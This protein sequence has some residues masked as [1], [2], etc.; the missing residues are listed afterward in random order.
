VRRHAADERGA[1]A[2]Y[3][4]LAGALIAGSLVLAVDVGR[5][6][7]V[8]TE[9]QNAADASAVAAAT[10]LDGGEGARKRAEALARET[11]LDS[12]S[13][14]GGELTV[15]SV[16]FYS[17]YGDTTTAATSD[18]DARFVEV[19]LDSQ[20]VHMM[21]GPVIDA[22]TGGSGS[23][24]KTLEATAVGTTDPIIC[25]APP[26][27]ICDLTEN[28][29]NSVDVLDPDNAGRQL[30]L[31]EG[32]GGGVAPG[33]YGLLC[34][35]G[36]C[37]A[38]VVEEGLADL[39]DGSCTGTMVETATGSKTNKV[40][41]GV[42]ARFDT[43]TFN[44]K[45]PARN[46]INFP[47]DTDLTGS[48]I[49][50]GGNW[51]RAGYWAAKHGGAPLPAALNG[52]TRYQVYLYE[53]GESFGR[54]DGGTGKSTQ[55]PVDDDL[56]DGYVLIEPPGAD[57]PVA[58]L[59]SKKNDNN[60]DGVPASTPVE[61]PKRRIVVAAILR[62]EAQNV[63]GHGEFDTRG[64]YVNLFLTETVSDPPV[65]DVYAEIVGPFNSE[66]SPDFH[67]NARLVQ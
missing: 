12:S 23:G 37:G 55:Y 61:D 58:V 42:N 27:M 6:A 35:D 41:N 31:K 49:I 17:Q 30:L 21:F 3:V 1:V 66:T 44:P 5:T 46:V 45:N 16:A 19:S 48:A 25:N 51:D 15:A 33:N 11:A 20:K 62:C 47:R 59:A 54:S 36:D 28:D 18:A 63:K 57:V 8:R 14:A 34:V 7:V 9:M 26:F 13:F 50:G 39:D 67:I 60:F 64:R 32:G 22:L 2:L 38:E 43:G 10:Q 56:L 65:A 52:A 40:R 53:L 24:S 29:K 4:A